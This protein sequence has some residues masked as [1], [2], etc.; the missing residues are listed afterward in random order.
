MSNPSRAELKHDAI[1]EFA[2][3]F[4]KKVVKIHLHRKSCSPENFC[5]ICNAFQ[6][7]LD[8]YKLQ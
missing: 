6:E 7:W 8:N 1:D 4:G 2:D 3:E 5:L